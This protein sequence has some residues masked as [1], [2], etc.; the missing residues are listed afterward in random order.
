MVT[1]PLAHDLHFWRLDHA[2]HAPSW[3]SGIGAE[4]CGGRWNP[5]GFQVVYASLDSATAILEVAVHK[6]FQTLDCVAHTL[7]AA[8]VRD[9]SRV[10]KVERKDVPNL[11]W[12]R[13]GTPSRSQQAFG[14]RLLEQHP[15]VLIPSCVSPYSWNLLMNPKLA[16]GLYELVLQEPFALDGRL[17]PPLQ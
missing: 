12:L 5:K 16:S 15:F 13:P 3:N 8:R 6:G 11:N 1:D 4:A 10:Y 14:A 7:T 2:R 9:T 17:N